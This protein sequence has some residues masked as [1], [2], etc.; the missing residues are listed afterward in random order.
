MPGDDSPAHLTVAILK[1]IRAELR[2]VNAR[3]DETNARLDATNTRLD[4]LRDDLGRRIT[5]SEIRT[6]TAIADL[7]G[8]VREMT[9]VLREQHDLRPRVERCEHDIAEL[10]A[11][12]EKAS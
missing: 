12:V 4:A 3:V 9:S 7:A 11:R 1:D 2:Q 10:R 6:A 8:S 5:E